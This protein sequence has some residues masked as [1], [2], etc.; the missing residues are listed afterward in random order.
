MGAIAAVVEN[1]E[2]LDAEVAS[3]TSGIIQASRVT[4]E[5]TKQQ[6]ISKARPAEASPAEEEA[7]LRAVY[8]GADF[9]EGVRAF[10]AK[11]KPNF[12]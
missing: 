6:L 11:E 12:R 3:L 7:L 4:I 2:E 9:T 10:L 5:V 1:P 8:T